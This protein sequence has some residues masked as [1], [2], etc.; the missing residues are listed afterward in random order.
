MQRRIEPPRS[1]QGAVGAGQRT[2]SV[3]LVIFANGI[4]QQ[5]WLGS[6]TINPADGLGLGTDKRI[7]ARGNG[8]GLR[9]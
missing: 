2:A 1:G 8:T 9:N 5:P 6:R 7:L 4:P 3:L